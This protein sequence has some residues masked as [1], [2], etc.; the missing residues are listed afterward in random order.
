MKKVSFSVEEWL[1]SLI[2]E[3]GYSSDFTINSIAAHSLILK[4]GSDFVWYGKM[5]KSDPV[6]ISPKYLEQLQSQLRDGI[7]THLYLYSPD[8]RE[9]VCHVGKIIGI[10]TEPPEHAPFVHKEPL[11]QYVSC[12][13]THPDA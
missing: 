5:V 1:M 13:S 6:S 3:G 2:D 10:Q 7:S 12:A 4:E 9:R 8:F 11:G